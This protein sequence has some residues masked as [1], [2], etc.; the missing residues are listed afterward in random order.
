MPKPILKDNNL[1]KILNE[2]IKLLKEVDK[3]IEIQFD[4][5]KI[6]FY[7]IVTRSRLKSLLI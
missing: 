7:L 2:N 5:T 1:T 4:K 6:K 3:T